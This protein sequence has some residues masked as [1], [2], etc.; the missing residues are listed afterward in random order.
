WQCKKQTIVATSTT[1]AE[2]VV[3][4]SYCGQVLWIQ[5][6]VLGYGLSMPCEAL[7]REIS[8]SILRF[9]MIMA[10]LQFCD[11]HNMVA[12]LENSEHNVDFHPIVDFVEASPLRYALTFKPTVYVPISDSF[13]PLLGSK[14]RK[15]EPR[16]SLP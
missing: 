2:Y 13:G 3:A 9:N 10:R 4:A 16:F 5:N 6:Q 8:S 14:L 11:Y 15:R 7:S 12:I 1:E